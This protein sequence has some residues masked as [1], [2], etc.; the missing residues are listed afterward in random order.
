MRDQRVG[1]RLRSIAIGDWGASDSAAL[2]FF[3]IRKIGLTDRS[4]HYALNT[5]QILEK[6]LRIFIFKTIISSTVI[7]NTA[8]LKV[9]AQDSSSVGILIR[10]LS[11]VL[12]N[13]F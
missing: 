8:I 12:V 2:A 3:L 7:F 10:I 5:I 11:A 9:C 1:Y 4:T 13:L 6:G